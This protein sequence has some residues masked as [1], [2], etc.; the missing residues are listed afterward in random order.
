MKRFKHLSLKK[1]HTLAV[2]GIALLGLTVVGTIAYN[3]ST[4]YFNNHFKLA[5]D[6]IEAT[7]IV[8]NTT[9]WQPCEEI[10]KTA[11]VTNKNDTP[12]YVRMK[13][14]EYWR[15]ANS[16]QIDHET[17]DLPLT[18]T[19]GSGTHK[20]AFYNTQNDDKWNLESD[21]YY[22]Y[23]QP[24]AAGA[25]TGSLLKS[26]EINCDA[27][28]GGTMTYS[29][30]GRVATTDP[31]P[32]TN[33]D[34]HIYVIF[35]ISDE[36]LTPG[37]H[38]A[39]CGNPTLLYD[40][41]ACRTNGP[42][43]NINFAVRSG[44]S[45]AADFGVNTLSAHKDDDFPV[46]YFRGTGSINNN[47]IYNGVCWKIVRTT[48]TG[49]VKISYSKTAENGQCID[50]VTH[51]YGFG[52][53]FSSYTFNGRT[54]TDGQ[55]IASLPAISYTYASS[56]TP[57]YALNNISGVY[58]W[59]FANDVEYDDTTHTYTLKDINYQG[60]SSVTWDALKNG[61]HYFCPYGNNLTSCATVGYL[62]SSSS[63][64]ATR[65]FV[66]MKDGITLDTYLDSIWGFAYDSSIKGTVDGPFFQ[67]LGLNNKLDDIEDTIYCNDKQIISGSFVS[68]DSDGT[69]KTRFAGYG[70][71]IEGGSDGKLHPTVDCALKR[72][73]YT[74]NES[75]TGNGAL[76]FPAGVM[77][78][79]EFV[80]T[81]M[82]NRYDADYTTGWA[83]SQWAGPAWEWTL[84]PAE[85]P[86]HV[87]Y[88]QFAINVSTL[89]DTYHIW[90]RPSTSSSPDVY[91]RPVISLKFGKTATGDGS[92][93]N[94]YRVE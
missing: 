22:Y 75:A 61:Y 92:A 18:W 12:R 31:S 30:D 59:Q 11:T 76:Q 44:S 82:P 81:G 60:D 68:K 17:T 78:A 90:E 71:L 65:Y 83:G 36:P 8:G 72:D 66:T 67:G 2:A 56:S 25:T 55:L 42:D 14:N 23:Y 89:M 70:R 87:E 86:D 6:S 48:G 45:G 9:T 34:F 20:Y 27:N 43:D 40:I 94:P 64:S 62:E 38:V 37:K 93:A 46:Y 4:A 21:G 50:D 15:V 63:Q 19:D 53:A 28:F 77:T 47:V 26:A 85:R 73:S 29:Q 91:V 57:H 10:P 79:D 54:N 33:S 24:L 58:E 1:K 5:A 35:E 49:G 41:I 52:S 84:T 32:Y 3:Q 7:D 39:D 51:T 13:I 69:E 16:A 74:V 88:N 80:L